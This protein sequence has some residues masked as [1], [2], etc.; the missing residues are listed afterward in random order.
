MT[1]AGAASYLTGLPEA[2]QLLAHS[3]A[4]VSL[5]L[6]AAGM[7]GVWDGDLVAGLVYGDAN[8]ARIYGVD[9]VMAAAGR[10]RGFYFRHIH[11]DDV[12][13]AREEMDR[14]FAGAPDYLNEHRILLPSGELRWVLTRGR[15]VRAEDGTPLRFAGVSV[16]ITDR[17]QAETRQA[18]LLALSDRLRSLTSPQ[19]IVETAV[20]ALGRYLGAN[21]IGFGKVLADDVNVTLETCFA[22]GVPSLE[23]VFEL[24]HFGAHHV[25]RCR[26]GLSI[27]QADVQDDPL[28]DH[29]VWAAID[30]RAHV[31]V[32]LIRGGRFTAALF[33]NHRAPRDWPVAEVALIED[34]AARLWDS[35][36][37]ARAEVA[38]RDA[39]ALLE[40]RIADALAERESIEDALRQAQK[41][42]AV[43]QLTGG[44]AHDFNNL[45]T[46]I[47]GSLEVLESR[48]A[49]GRTDDLARYIVAARE[50]ADRAAAVTH[51]LLAF[52]RRQT[53]DARPTA[54]NQLVTDMQELVRR[55]VGP[56]IEVALDLT[57]NAW[58]I[59]VDRNQM[60]NA[61]LNL[62]I[63]ARD[64]M[65]DGGRLTIETTNMELA[66]PTGPTYQV[67]PGHYMSLCVADSGMGMTGDVVSRAFDPFFTTKPIGKGTGLGLSMI[68]GFVRQSG[69]HIHIESAPGQGTKICIILPRHEA[70][71]DAAPAP[72]T[73]PG[74]ARASGGQTVLVVDDEPAVRMLLA[75]VLADAGYD[76]L[77]AGNGAAGLTLLQSA[78]P[79]DLLLTDVGLP[80]GMNGRQLADAGRAVRPGLPV[81]FVTGYAETTVIGQGPM[82]EGMHIMTK[83]FE[84]HALVSRV[85][86]VL[87]S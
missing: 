15:L 24:D 42:E 38:L 53:L 80:G 62:C 32:P 16:D 52:S 46:G 29:A 30:T 22:D 63:N 8:F 74:P 67:P 61:L 39:N 34:V 73:T 43:G 33:V 51:R 81:L 65:P 17:K 35:L 70:G 48:L 28:A 27:V 37:R 50:G 87:A 26:R 6:T 79:I 78:R 54:V 9:P 84:M 11:P 69:G 47:A 82:D 31:T 40:Q 12:Q 77:E 58:P 76:I 41:M 2:E 64:A 7:I 56:S 45:L 10:P 3:E 60:E 72:A 13:G 19:E 14:L 5:A 44:L 59:L 66:A 4:R 71:L 49:Q 55:T 23:G 86:A 25:A 85:D 57:P 75:E 21:R 1:Q 68:Y 36:E 18:F 83:P 20:T